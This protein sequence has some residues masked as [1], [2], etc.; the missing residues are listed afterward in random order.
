VV[1]RVLCLALTD[2]VGGL[3]YMP[4]IRADV[5]VCAPL[6]QSAPHLFINVLAFQQSGCCEGDAAD[7]RRPLRVRA[8]SWRKVLPYW[9]CRI[10]SALNQH[11]GP[12]AASSCHG[13]YDAH[14]RERLQQRLTALSGRPPPPLERRRGWK[15]TPVGDRLLQPAEGAL[16]AAA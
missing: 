7:A 15:P 3:Y 10:V 12:A 9:L 5:F 6:E 8:D 13:L 11:E 2:V 4:T 16:Q 14:V 1:E